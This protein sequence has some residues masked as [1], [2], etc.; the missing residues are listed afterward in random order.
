M[1]ETSDVV[2][3]VI[4]SFLLGALLSAHIAS[5][6]ENA[7]WQDAIKNGRVSIATN[8]AT[9]VKVTILPK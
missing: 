9:N 7:A 8:V 1:I 4:A 2:C 5:N 6:V 3:F